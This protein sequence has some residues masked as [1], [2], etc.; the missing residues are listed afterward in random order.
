MPY[1]GDLS[2]LVDY[3]ID[4][5]TQSSLWQKQSVLIINELLRG[6][7]HIGEIQTRQLCK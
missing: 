1:T 5:F 2:V 3:F 6:S 4:Y 7:A